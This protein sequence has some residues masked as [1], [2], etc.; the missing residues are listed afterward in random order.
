MSLL[1]SE[2]ASPFLCHSHPLSAV[3]SARLLL[4]WSLDSQFQCRTTEVPHT[5]WFQWVPPT[6]GTWPFQSKAVFEAIQLAVILILTWHSTSPLS[7]TSPKYCCF[8][9][10]WLK[11]LRALQ[12]TRSRVVLI[13]VLSILFFFFAVTERVLWL[14]FCFWT[15]SHPVIVLQAVGPYTGQLPATL[16]DWMNWIIKWI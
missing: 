13:L 15:I 3:R 7:S 5:C 1:D 4:W 6:I 12:K 16:N 9:L 14:S 8:S 10:Q 11:D 2:N